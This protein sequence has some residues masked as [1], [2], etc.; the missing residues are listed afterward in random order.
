MG[1]RQRIFHWRKKQPNRM[2]RYLLVFQLSNVH[3][4]WI[5][6][7]HWRWS[8]YYLLDLHSVEARVRLVLLRL[9]RSR[10]HGDEV[11]AQWKWSSRKV[12]CSQGIFT[13]VTTTQRLGC[14]YRMS[15]SCGGR[16]SLSYVLDRYLPA[17]CSAPILLATTSLPHS[18]CLLG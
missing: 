9:S 13:V 18:S 3:L 17:S 6:S 16:K 15:S 1:R 10:L 14:L 11:A 4:I 12:Q 8:M 5:F 2:Q 7:P